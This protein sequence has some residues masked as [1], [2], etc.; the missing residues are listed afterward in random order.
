M[1]RETVNKVLAEIGGACGFPGLQ[2]DDNGDASMLVNDGVE[3]FLHHDEVAQALIVESVLGELRADD[4]ELTLERLMRAN[5]LGIGTVG[6]TL[7]LGP[8]DEIVLARLVPASSM[9]RAAVER[10]LRWQSTA[11][12]SLRPLLEGDSAAVQAARNADAE[13]RRSPPPMNYRLLV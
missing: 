10:A 12:I 7:A 8:H 11:V 1:D 5:R 2:L 3:V 6:A 9:T 4:A 13:T